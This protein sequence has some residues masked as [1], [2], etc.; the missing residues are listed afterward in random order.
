MN[1][2]YVLGSNY[3]IGLSIIRC[4]GKNNIPVVTVDYSKDGAYGL[5][6]KYCSENLIGPHYQRES[7]E[8]VK[9]LISRAIAEKEKPFLYP[10]SDPYV[11]FIDNHFDELK[12]HFLI[13]Q[14][15]KGLNTHLM[16]KDLLH[17]LA[18]KH[19]VAVPETMTPEFP[20]DPA[21]VEA[22]I[23]YPCL[24]KPADSHLFVA[25]FRTKLFRVQNREELVEAVRKSK[26]AGLDVIIQQMIPGFD[27]CMYT[28]DVYMN[29]QSQ[30]THWMTC[31]K[32]RQYPINYGAS[33]YTEQKHVPELF[34]IGA[35]FLS[36]IGYTGFAEIEFKKDERTGKFYLIE[37]NVR[38]TNLNVLLA[39]CGLNMPLIDYRELTGNP[40]AP[41][42]VS[43]HTKKAFWYLYEDL[44]AIKGY[45]RTGQLSAFNVL[46]SLGR[47]KAYAI[48]D[49]KD[50]KPFYKFMELKGSAVK[51]KLTS[52]KA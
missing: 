16:N 35:P 27:D 39:S 30:P 36:A 26:E 29:Q 51:R 1:K 22:R 21:K 33:V 43:T 38:T 40:M 47:K 7:A 24:V 11:E 4:L 34:D 14:T 42:T 9:F 50:P 28:F 25:H 8:L 48:W 5:Y 3:Y 31:K 37:I 41:H 49:F 19:G 10:S 45:I 13:A 23:G 6:S 46:R 17:D 15:K 32:I 44:L 18:S 2:A 12:E 52:K 20:F